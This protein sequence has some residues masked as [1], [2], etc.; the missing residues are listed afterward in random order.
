LSLLLNVPH[1]PYAF[2][3][4]MRSMFVH[5]RL[6]TESRNL[7]FLVDLDKSIDMV[8]NFSSPEN[9]T[10]INQVARYAAYEVQGE[11]PVRISKL[12]EENPNEDGIVI[13]DETRLR[14]IITNLAT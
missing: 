14:Q 13:G 11:S 8:S 5:L 10:H 12:L 9:I 6:A 4:V 3:Q 1:Q 7:D 2:H